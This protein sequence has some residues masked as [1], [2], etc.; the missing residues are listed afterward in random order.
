LKLETPSRT[1][2]IAVTTDFELSLE[3]IAR[4][5]GFLGYGKPADSIWF[6]GKEEGL[7]DMD[8]DDAMKNLRA[9]ATFDSIMDLYRA[10][11]QLW[12]NGLPIDFERKI[13]STQVWNSWRKS[14][15]LGM[16]MKRGRTRTRLTTTSGPS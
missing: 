7:G 2:A 12:E 1:E 4:I 10:H 16:D 5:A 3:E 14:C 8:E 11:L 13:P 9:R 15:A 6:I